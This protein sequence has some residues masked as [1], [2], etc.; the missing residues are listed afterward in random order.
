METAQDDET[1]IRFKGNGVTS[2]L[3]PSQLLTYTNDYT[4]LPYGSNMGQFHSSGVTLWNYAN[5]IGTFTVQNLLSGLHCQLSMMI[6]SGST[7]KQGLIIDSS[8]DD[9]AIITLFPKGTDTY[10]RIVIS[11]D[12]G[13]IKLYNTSNTNTV[14]INRTGDITCTSLHV[15]GSITSTGSNVANLSYTVVSTF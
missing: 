4:T 6:K 15:N 10:G 5:I 14:T 8:Y 2:T 11:T 3:S 1:F 7:V 9:G 12:D 13:T